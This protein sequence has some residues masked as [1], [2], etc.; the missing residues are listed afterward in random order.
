[1]R[2]KMRKKDKHAVA[3]GSKGGKAAARA[4]T[5]EEQTEFSRLGGLSRW[6]NQTEFSTNPMAVYQ[7]E[8]RARMRL[9]KLEKEMRK[10]EA[11]AKALQVHVT[12]IENATVYGHET[13]HCDP[14]D[15]TKRLFDYDWPTIP[16]HEA[17]IGDI[18]IL[19]D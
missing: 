11:D 15:C 18:Y 9:E 7:R 1:M 2:K 16:A 13:K 17:E 14:G 3:L 10:K 12:R 4:R 8:R 5:P 19:E 6:K